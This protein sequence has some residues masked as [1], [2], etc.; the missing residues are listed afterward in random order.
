MQTDLRLMK[1]NR[2]LKFLLG[3]TELIIAIQYMIHDMIQP[4]KAQIAVAVTA[5]PW[6]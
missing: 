4:I 1:H 5:P 2:T 6:H 3:T